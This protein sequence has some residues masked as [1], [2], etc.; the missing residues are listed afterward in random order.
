MRRTPRAASPHDLLRQAPGGP[1]TARA[2][3]LLAEEFLLLDHNGREFG[4]L[5]MRGASGAELRLGECVAKFESSERGYRMIADGEEVL[6]ATPKGK[7]TGELEVSCGGQSYEAHPDLLRNLAIALYPQS[8]E[9][10]VRLSGGLL[11]RGYEALLA[12]EDGC[13]LPVA[14]FLL[15]YVAANRRRAYRKGSLTRGAAV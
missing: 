4:R 10:L 12:T 13:A 3:G 11:G 8:G 14:V 15:W 6:V 2:R 7:S 9:R 5:R 1:F